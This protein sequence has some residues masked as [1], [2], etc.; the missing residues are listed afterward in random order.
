MRRTQDKALTGTGVLGLSQNDELIFFYYIYTPIL[1]MCY[2]IC[3]AYM[4]EKK[5]LLVLVTLTVLT[6]PDVA[7]DDE[8]DDPVRFW[9]GSRCH[10]GLAH[11]MHRCYLCRLL[12]AFVCCTES[13]V[14]VRWWAGTPLHP[15]HTYT[16]L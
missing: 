7:G 2:R 9:Y 13:R 3:Y 1:L 10:H 4:K 6:D 16:V 5:Q 11:G 8:G 12:P 15:R 14:V